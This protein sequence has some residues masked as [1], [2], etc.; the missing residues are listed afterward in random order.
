MDG[1]TGALRFRIAA[2]RSPMYRNAFYLIASEAVSAPLGLAFWA[3]VARRYPDADAGI[4]SVL[5]ASATLLATAGTLGLNLGLVRFLPGGRGREGAIINSSATVTALTT[6]LLAAIFAAGSGLWTP[7]VGFLASDPL[8][9]AIFVAFVAVWAVHLL[10]DYAFI[11]LSDSRSVLVRA[12]TVG[13]LKLGLPIAL[14]PPLFVPMGLFSAWSLGL[15]ASN[16]LAVA[17]LFPRLI[18]GYKL[19]PEL[20]RDAIA[21]MVRYS[22]GSQAT[23]IFGAL[24]GL[25]F[26]LIIV[27][28]LPPANA[29]YFYVAWSI[30]TVLFI[31]PGSIFL[32][33]FAE[34]SRATHELRRTTWNGLL[35]AFALL[36]PAVA[37]TVLLSGTI[38]TRV[39]SAG[40]AAAAPVLNVLALA[41]FP[42][43]VNL[44]YAASLRVQKRLGRLLLLY[45]STS[46]A[47]LGFGYVFLPFVGLLGPALAFVGVQ[48][49]TAAFTARAML[50]EGMLGRPARAAPKV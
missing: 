31:V 14:I 15:L 8:S 11:G 26:P 38:L 1:L 13:L 44:A 43:T 28:V 7:V 10:F 12:F 49:V 32:S 2:M 46:L 25:G 33:V 36:G 37:A 48:G 27:R 4:G 24:P 42:V 45:A 40:Y 34:A 29:A 20:R 6:A 41:S 50:R 3:L 35:L 47:A 23:T 39:F 16:A 18:P 30:A 21:P 5:I 17:L 9:F 22:I 19:R